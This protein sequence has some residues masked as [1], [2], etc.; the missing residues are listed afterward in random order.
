MGPDQTITGDSAEWRLN[1][2]MATV[3]FDELSARWEYAWSKLSESEES[4][5]LFCG[6]AVMKAI[7]IKSG[8]KNGWIAV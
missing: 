7:L 3:P 6:C 5:R 4:F 2:L 1:E 8:V